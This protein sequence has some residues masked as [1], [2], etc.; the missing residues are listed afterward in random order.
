MEIKK[1]RYKYNQITP[2]DKTRRNRI[3]ILLALL[4]VLVFGYVA[5]ALNKPIPAIAV[6][7]T[8]L[9]I[10]AAKELV[11]PWPAS[12]QSAIGST[13][14]G[15]LA[16]YSTNEEVKPIASITKIITALAIIEKSPIAPGE[17]GQKYVLTEEDVAIFNSYVA[18]NGAV[19]PV[20]NGQEI[21][22]QQALQ[23]ILIASANNIADS[24]VIKTFGSLDAYTAY[25]NNYV[26]TKGL[27]KT[28]ISD[29]SGFSAQTVST[30]SDLVN[31][32][33]IALEQPVIKQIVQQK[34]ADLGV[35]GVI[36]NTNK[37]LAEPSVIGIKTGTTNEAGS[38]LL[39]AS[40]HIVNSDYSVTIVGVIMGSTDSNTVTKDSKTLLDA[41]KT[42]FGK[43]DIAKAGTIVGNAKS[44]WGQ[45]AVLKLK[46]DLYINTWLAKEL[47]PTTELGKIIT[48]LSDGQ[49]VGNA[50]VGDSEKSPVITE[51]D[52]SNPSV[53]WRLTNLF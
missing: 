40:D 23:A 28:I 13:K 1:A 36:N 25:A 53:W 34:Q 41:A 43:V 10:I 31:I 29:A 39:F 52:I 3:I 11:L 46:D 6:T 9:Q 17:P 48:P 21:T 19:L 49:I 38:C 30:P 35:F 16:S 32:G 8:P 7:E 14:Y 20:K 44:E 2:K 45:Q 15:V 33:K 4:L 27:E 51:G 24:I 26:K 47:K 5:T 50:E 18:K 37:L 22:Q 42:Y 12:G